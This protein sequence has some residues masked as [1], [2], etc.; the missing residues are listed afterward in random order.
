MDYFRVNG[1]KYNTPCQNKMQEGD[2]YDE[3][4]RSPNAPTIDKCV[5]HGNL[6]SPGDKLLL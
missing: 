1:H 2:R 6:C 5:I 3:E 4:G